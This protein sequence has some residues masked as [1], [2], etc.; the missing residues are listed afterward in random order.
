MSDHL[1]TKPLRDALIGV[2]RKIDKLDD[3]KIN[4]ALTD[5]IQF[6]IT[7]ISRLDGEVNRG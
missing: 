5:C 2:Q 3:T 7:E 1:L 4:Q 6:F